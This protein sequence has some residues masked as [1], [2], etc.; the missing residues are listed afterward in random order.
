M[1]YKGNLKTFQTSFWSH[2]VTKGMDINNKGLFVTCCLFSRLLETKANPRETKGMDTIAYLPDA[3]EK[4][5][6]S[7][8]VTEYT[9]F[10]IDSASI[11]VKLIDHMYD[12]YDRTL[13]VP[14]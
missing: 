11:Q 10:S 5:K 3:V 12:E 4:T 7:S 2:L 6:V 14:A 1:S 8:V 9:R 13:R